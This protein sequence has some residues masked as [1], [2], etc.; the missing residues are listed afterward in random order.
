[1]QTAQS[2][3]LCCGLAVTDLRDQAFKKGAFASAF[4]GAL[5][6]ARPAII[7]YHWVYLY[8]ETGNPQSLEG[9]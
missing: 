5:A 1:M 6:A 2:L 8:S 7:V 9:L 4:H 3:L